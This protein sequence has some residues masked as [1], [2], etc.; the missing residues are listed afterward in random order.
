MKKIVCILA[1]AVMALG[2]ISCSE[3]VQD[4]LPPTFK[5][6]KYTPTT[7]HPGDSVWVSA[8]IDQPGENVYFANHKGIKW[9]MKVDTL[10]AQGGRGQYTIT[11][12]P[13]CTIGDSEYKIGLRIPDSAD[14]DATVTINF[15]ARYDNAANGNPGTYRI[16]TTQ[17]GYFGKFGN[18]TVKSILYSEVSGSLN[19]ALE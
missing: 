16:S 1:L 9:T 5:G 11:K 15:Y 12:E 18:S 13:Y 8:C 17:Q 3:D 7:P 14:P 19:I 4:A 6:F 2:I 10:N